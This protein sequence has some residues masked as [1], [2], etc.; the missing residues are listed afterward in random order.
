MKKLVFLLV[1][2]VTVLNSN[3]FAQSDNCKINLSSYWA[4]TPDWI[5][6]NNVPT[7]V[8]VGEQVT[9]SLTL[10][11]TY[12]WTI[13]STYPGVTANGYSNSINFTTSDLSLVGNNYE[14]TINLNPGMPTCPRDTT[15]FV[16]VLEAPANLSLVATGG[17]VVCAGT[18]VDFV[19]GADNALPGSSTYT[20][21]V[22]G[23]PV[24]VSDPT[25]NIFQYTPTHGQSISFAVSNGSCSAILPPAQA[26]AMTV[27]NNPTPVVAFDDLNLQNHFCDA[28][29]AVINETSG[30]ANIASWQFFIAETPTTVASPTRS[31]PV[32]MA[33]NGQSAYVIV[34]DN[35][36]CQGTSNT[37][38]IQVDQL[39]DLTVT[40]IPS[41]T[42]N[43]EY[44]TLQVS[45]FSGTGPF[46]VEFWNPTHDTEYEIV[47][48]N[49]QL[50][51][52]VGP[53]NVD[54]DIPYGTQNVHTRIVSTT[55]GCSNFPV[56][57]P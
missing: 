53:V 29:T 39:P 10:D 17:S 26:V 25:S 42:C 22:N 15:V 38:N 49:P 3:I 34:T 1:V 13:S 44:M 30:N 36:G 31:W 33:Q 55:T 4:E 32:S 48:S 11:G 41:S 52:G 16:S 56:I 6:F 12:A 20:W 24:V 43:G 54:V 7:S 2:A 21:S 23:I 9:F 27:Y 45:G 28:Q 50:P 37:L 57:E 40:P 18:Q 19:A 51:V 47:S 46:N 5:S 14:F 8:C 35:N